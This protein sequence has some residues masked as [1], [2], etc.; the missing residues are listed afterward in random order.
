MKKLLFFALVCAMTIAC[1]GNS[2]TKEA[3]TN[4][5]VVVDSLD[6]VMT[7]TISIDSLRG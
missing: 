7:D 3:T 6:S 2:T 5:T 4:D 1:T